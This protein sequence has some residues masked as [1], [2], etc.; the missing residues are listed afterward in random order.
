MVRAVRTCTLMLLLGGLTAC[1]GGGPATIP[2][3]Q[4]AVVEHANVSPGTGPTTTLAVTALAVRTGTIAE[5]EAGGLEVDAEDRTKIPTYVDVRFENRGTQTI[6]RELRVSMEDKDGGLI[7]P[8][9][10]FNYGDIVFAPCPDKTEGAFAP[11]ESFETCVLFL[12]APERK[13]V[14]VSFLPHVPGTDTDWVYWAIP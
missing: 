10:V 1:G 6:D 3:G 2:L 7:S 11:A 13:G 12:V 8:V 4:E 5:L 9:V 14:R